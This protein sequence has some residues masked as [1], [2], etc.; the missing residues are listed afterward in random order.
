MKAFLILLM[1]PVMVLA[2]C[3]QEKKQDNSKLTTS[4]IATALQMK[5]W[6][7]KVPA[8]METKCLGIGIKNGSEKIKS[9]GG[10][11]G[12]KEGV[13][14]VIVW[15]WDKENLSYSIIANNGSSVIGG[16]LNPQF[17]DKN[18]CVTSIAIPDGQIIKPDETFYVKSS[19]HSVSLAEKI[20]ADKIGYCFTF[21][22]YA[23]P[24]AK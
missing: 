4:D 13:C 17:P 21:E 14:K 18:Q 9:F 1:I 2:G 7:L 22:N 20:T 19:K 5:W 11:S 10:M 8:G 16:V 15:G 12:L 6:C 3:R 23:A 24:L